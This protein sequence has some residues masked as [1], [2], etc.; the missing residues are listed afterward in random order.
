MNQLLQD[1][2]QQLIGR[3]DLE[4][5]NLEKDF[6]NLLYVENNLVKGEINICAVYDGEK[7]LYYPN[8]V[9]RK[10]YENTF[11][12]D[13]YEIYINLLDGKVFET[14]R[15]IP[16]KPDFH[17][18]PDDSCCLGLFENPRPK[19]LLDFIRNYIL[20]FFVWQ[21]YYKK[22]EEKPP[23]GE[24]SH[25]QA[26]IIEFEND[27]KNIGRNNMCYCGSKK[28]FKYCCGK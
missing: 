22:Y 23:W 5:K 18:N 14:G 7:L 2:L 26:G 10:K 11:V 12:E 1:F 21:A 19:T 28:K 16:K 9:V 20:P 4:M 17:I 15:K 24:Y 6:P 27:K 8:K 3:I 13:C 25:G